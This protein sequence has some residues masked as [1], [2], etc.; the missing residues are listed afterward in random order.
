M[1]EERQA[2]SWGAARQH[3][4]RNREG[5]GRRPGPAHLDWRPAPDL[6]LSDPQ[7]A[8]ATDDVTPESRFAALPVCGIAVSG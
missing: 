2:G 1:N 6:P 7:P 5:A 8:A 4:D 3:R